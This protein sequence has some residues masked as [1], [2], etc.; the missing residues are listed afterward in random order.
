MLDDSTFIYAFQEWTMSKDSSL[1]ELCR[2]FL[3]REKTKKVYA[4]DN[5]EIILNKFKQDIRELFNAYKYNITDL[6][7]EFF[8]IEKGTGFSAYN[9]TKENIWIQK[10]GIV[11]DISKVS[12]II[13]CPDDEDKI[14]EDDRKVIFINYNLVRKLD[15]ENTPKLIDDLK[16][17][18]KNYDVRNTIEIEKKYFVNQEKVFINI[19]TFLKNSDYKV[20]VKGD[21]QQ[22]D[23]YFDTNNYYLVG[24]K[25]KLDT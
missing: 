2:A 3:N 13:T 14:W 20:L 6:K 9:K 23:T 18:I 15:I 1:A 10:N 5:S 21:K 24:C 19:L 17:L 7:K 8:W 22:I 25:M 4:L 11:N 16:F 12:K